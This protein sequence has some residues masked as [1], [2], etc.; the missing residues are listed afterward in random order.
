M[1]SSVREA[2]RSI[3]TNSSEEK[4]SDIARRILENALR[5]AILLSKNENRE[6]TLSD[7]LKTL[8]GQYGILRDAV[9]LLNTG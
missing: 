2:V 6:I 9:S 1:Q 5:D 7:L 8:E 4:I 3:L